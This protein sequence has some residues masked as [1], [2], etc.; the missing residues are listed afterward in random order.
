[1]HYLTLVVLKYLC[2]QSVANLTT[3]TVYNT[4]IY[5]QRYIIGVICSVLSNS[6]LGDKDLQTLHKASKGG[7]G[8]GGG[9]SKVW[10]PHPY[11]IKKWSKV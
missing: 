2:T 4:N 5:I 9:V 10:Q 11:C 8:G 6:P 3:I 1:M 7:G